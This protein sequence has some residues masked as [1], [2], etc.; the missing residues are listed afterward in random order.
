MVCGHQTPCVAAVSAPL[1]ARRGKSVVPSAIDFH[2]HLYPADLPPFA[3]RTGD[4]RWPA[5]VRDPEPR[6]MQ[7]GDVFR[8]IDHSYFDVG[9]RLA[10]MDQLQIGRQVLS[11]L[12]VLLPHWAD[13]GPAAAWC[14]AVNDAIAEVAGTS[15]RFLPMGILPM[16]DPGAAIEEVG[17]LAAGGFVGVELGT[18]LDDHRDLGDPAADEVLTAIADAGLRVLV[19]PTRSAVLPRGPAS[20]ASSLGLL[21]DTALAIGSALVRD[22]AVVRYPKTCVAHGGG[23]LVWAWHQISVRTGSPARLPEWLHVDTAGCTPAHAAFAA[24]VLGPERVI[25]GSDLPATKNVRVQELVE[26]LVIRRPEVVGSNP[27]TFLDLDE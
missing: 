5:L 9:T 21:T 6:I 8:V 15:N 10:R 27:R 13:S 19:H 24:D 14:R 11:P 25:F 18:A 20:L 3:A 17:R 7:G 22:D 16:Q 26:S 12:P 2:A 4:C 1:R 23:T